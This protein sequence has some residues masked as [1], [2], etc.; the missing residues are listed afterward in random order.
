MWDC[1]SYET[2]CERF[3]GCNQKVFLLQLIPFEGL[4][5]YMRL[6]KLGMRGGD[7]VLL[8]NFAISFLLL[9]G[10][11]QDENGTSVGWNSNSSIVNP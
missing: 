11:C 10:S 8:D 2:K 7:D 1:A 4:S 6:Y 5:N 9:C 3:E